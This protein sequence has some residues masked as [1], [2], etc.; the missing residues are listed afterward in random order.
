MGL[1][2][3]LLSPDWWKQDSLKK[4]YPPGFTHPSIL[5]ARSSTWIPSK[6]FRLS[7][8]LTVKK[9][10]QVMR[11]GYHLFIREIHEQPVW[12]NQVDGSI[13][14]FQVRRCHISTHKLDVLVMPIHTFILQQHHQ[15]NVTL[16]HSKSYQTKVVRKQT[17][18]M[19][20]SMKSRAMTSPAFWASS[21]VKRPMPAP[22][23]STFFPSYGG[24]K[25]ST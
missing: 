24:I 3:R 10:K 4:M 15:R 11:K 14:D 5:S 21:P 19:A 6:S 25:E 7:S 16:K 8:L 18:L 9:K 12:E 23:S 17:F 1:D 2:L 20:L 22:S 13:F